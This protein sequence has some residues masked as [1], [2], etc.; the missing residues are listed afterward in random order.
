MQELLIRSSGFAFF[1]RKDRE[2]KYP[3]GE[4]FIIEPEPKAVISCCVDNKFPGSK[5]IVYFHGNGER[6]SVYLNKNKS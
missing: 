6:V 1:P 4:E 3:Q 2:Y 5:T